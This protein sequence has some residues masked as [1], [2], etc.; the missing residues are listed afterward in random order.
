M[1]QRK[2]NTLRN[3]HILTQFA[4]LFNLAVIVWGAYVR[5][6]GSGA[7]CGSHWPLCNGEVI[8]RSPELAT[9]IEFTH[10]ITSGMCLIFAAVIAWMGRVATQG[11]ILRRGSRAVLLFTLSEALIGAGLVLF[12]YV[13]LDPS[14]GRAISISLHLANTFLLLASLTVTERA[15]HQARFGEAAMTWKK[16]G[17]SKLSTTALGL[18][19]LVGV[20]GA[21]TALGDTLFKATS[22][23]QGFAQDFE[24]SSHYLLKLRVFH[25]LLAVLL[26]VF[27]FY[28]G[29]KAV[30]ERPH[31]T[32]L[33]RL[34]FSLKAL[35]AFQLVLG[36]VNLVWL[37]PTG[38]Q[39]FH[40]LTAEFLWICL[41]MVVA[42]LHGLGDEKTQECV[43]NLPNPL[44]TAASACVSLP[45]SASNPADGSRVSSSI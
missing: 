24:P 7:G 11:S 25:P 42:Q 30:E 22:L 35:V 23:A 10:R 14:L 34:S 29:D 38:L 16:S 15:A 27:L 43:A 13:A 37:A 26:G 17:L 40:L 2:P 6:S 28:F 5:T 36:T 1:L 45:E 9:M 41:V 3:L 33:A 31:D 19:L 8:P 21:L 18:M 44:T 12:G 39:L 4:L 32:K 20:I